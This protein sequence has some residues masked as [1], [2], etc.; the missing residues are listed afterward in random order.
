MPVTMLDITQVKEDGRVSTPYPS[1]VSVTFSP[2]MPD[3]SHFFYSYMVG[4][5]DDSEYQQLA[6]QEQEQDLNQDGYLERGYNSSLPQPQDTIPVDRTFCDY[7]E[8]FS[9]CSSSSSFPAYACWDELPNCDEDAFMNDD[10]PYCP[11][12]FD[13]PLRFVQVDYVRDEVGKYQA[14]FSLGDCGARRSRWMD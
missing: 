6:A 3:K 10:P 2:E 7:H 14:V 13:E 8:C 9:H 5:F 12:L 1:P 11:P 4:D